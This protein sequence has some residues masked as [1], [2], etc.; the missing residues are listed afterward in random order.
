MKRTLSRHN[1]SVALFY[2]ALGLAGI[3]LNACSADWSA[4]LS[5][6]Q[7]CS[8][9]AGA[10][11]ATFDAATGTGGS[12]GGPGGGPGGGFAQPPEWGGADG[13]GASG[14]ESFPPN[15][16]MPNIPPDL[17]AVPDACMGLSMEPKVL[18]VS[19]D[20][21]N[22]MGS[23]GHVREII[24]IG[25]EPSVYRIRTY[26][27]LNYYRIA[28]DA[29][30]YGSL[31][32]VPQ[33]E[34]TMD[35][36]VAEFQIGVR[37]FDAFP[38][39]RAMN[40]TFLVDNSG[41]MKGPGMDRARAAVHALASKFINGDVVSLITTDSSTPKLDGIK[42]SEP[43]DSALLTAVDTLATAGVTDLNT[44]LDAA[45]KLAEKH[46]DDKRMN[47]VIFIS[48]GG[49]D[50]GTTDVDLIAQRSRDGIAEG[51][52]FVGIGTGPA[53]SYNDALMD[54]ITD[55]GRGAYV[56]IDSADEAQRV[57]ADRF[58]ETMDIAAR[59]VQVELTLPWYF[60][61][62]GISTELPVSATK[63]EAQHLA[64]SDAMVFF[65]KTTACH[66]D[67]YKR[68]DPVTVR[69]FWRTRDGYEP[70][71]TTN[72][73]RLADLFGGD[74]FR[75]AKARAIVAYAEALKGCGFDKK[76]LFLCEN[77]TE[78]KKVTKQK[79]IEARD[80]ANLAKNGAVDAELDEI[81]GI[82]N[83]HTLLQ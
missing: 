34:M 77:E 7:P 65:L 73:I 12:G 45:Y 48:D 18:Y 8:E 60:N 28:Y 9:G 43:N 72:E 41:S 55:A 64:P 42:I 39:R 26:E 75:M 54:A 47:R 20:D 13:A 36:L 82:I 50:V 78:R 68:Q 21:S 37:S 63:V 10:C 62:E 40:F 38:V 69:V 81:I 76:G 53:L 14:L 1:V 74:A 11:E 67:I 25:F 80:L 3:A 22:S 49:V 15:S 29:P 33:M 61:A 17:Q 46:R 56:Y 4:D 66:P 30:D 79:L 59:S 31:S 23:P 19:A 32:I 52:Y 24:N 57:L 58:A 27:F 44:S 6:A 83:R 2:A 5:G 16:D 35:P 51:I 71:V 70:R